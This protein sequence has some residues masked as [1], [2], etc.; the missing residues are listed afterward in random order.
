MIKRILVGI[1]GTPFTPVAIERSV[2]LA[3]EHGARITAVSVV[4]PD[5]TCR[6]GPVPPG[7]SVYAKRMCENRLSVTK[8][9]MDEAVTLLKERCRSLDVT[10]QIEEETG[11]IFDLLISHARYN[12]LTVF[13]LRSIFEYE[14]GEDPEADLLRLLSNGVRPVL[15]VSDRFRS[16]EKVMIAYSGSMESAK[17]MR[18][19]VQF[20]LWPDARLEI[21]HFG[22]AETKKLSLLDDAADYCKG[23]GYETDVRIVPGTAGEHLLPAAQDMN[24]DLI[25]MGNSIRSIWLRKILGDTVLS[26]LTRADRPLFLSQ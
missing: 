11:N 26:T 1:G 4:D 2:S 8:S 3:F 16:I 18:H 10:L 20:G 19:F 23:Y 7:A 5:R 6:M 15:A 12:D 24:A 22:D 21:V 17:A 14:L 13:G 25:V 9:K